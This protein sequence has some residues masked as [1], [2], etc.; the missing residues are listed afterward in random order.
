ME[1][2]SA[3]ARPL[4]DRIQTVCA[5]RGWNAVR[6]ERETGVSRQ[7]IAKWKTAPRAPQAATVNTVARVLG[8]DLTEALRLAGVIPSEEPEPEI[9][10]T[11]PELT[12][13]VEERIAKARAQ[14]AAKM[15]AIVE[16]LRSVVGDEKTDRLLKKLD[17]KPSNC[18][19]AAS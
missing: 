10:T 5:E 3:P 11:L 1:Q 16:A 9:P 14:D 12:A 13:M 19:D 15:A 18:S 6:L 8:I 4:W 17:D 2:R 7:T